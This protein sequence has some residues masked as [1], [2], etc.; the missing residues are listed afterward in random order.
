MDGRH[1]GRMGEVWVPTGKWAR[2][3]R[4]RVEAYSPVVHDW[5]ESEPTRRRPAVT[6]IGILWVLVPCLLFGWSYCS[7]STWRPVDRR[8]YEGL[9]YFK[10][11]SA[12]QLNAF[13][14]KTVSSVCDPTL[15]C[16]DR[17]VELRKRTD[18]G[19][20]APSGMEEELQAIR[21]R[22][23]EIMTEARHRRIPKQFANEYKTSLLAIQSCNRATQ[24]L[25]D[26]FDQETPA[27][28]NKLYKESIKRS[29]KARKQCQEVRA[30]FTT[31][32]WKKDYPPVTQPRASSSCPAP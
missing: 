16:V 10:D 11:G 19:T 6:V 1:D 9:T 17:L 8:P 7:Q 27:A 13:R 21:D 2:S 3:W 14:K 28:R 20:V 30:Y 22:L 32:A 31:D 18:K 12:P 15:D 29:N 4:E 23:R 5:Y 25:E 24:S 26:S